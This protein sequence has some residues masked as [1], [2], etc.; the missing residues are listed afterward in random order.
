MA[1]CAIPTVSRS[2]CSIR[3]ARWL[4]PEEL[5]NMEADGSERLGIAEHVTF[6]GSVET[7]QR[8]G[9]A[10]MRH[11]RKVQ[12]EMG[13]KNPLIVLDDA[14]LTV[15]LRCAVQGAFSSTGPGRRLSAV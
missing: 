13:G 6:T 12:L 2:V 3:A 9:E 10:C 8:V 15:A 7:G 5:E 11:M 14:D 4:V 1:A